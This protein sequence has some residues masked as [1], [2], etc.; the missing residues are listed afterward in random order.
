MQILEKVELQD[1]QSRVSVIG[2]P[3][4]DSLSHRGTCPMNFQRVHHNTTEHLLLAMDQD[5][6]G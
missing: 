6:F 5:G 1:C 2:W 3:V 4:H